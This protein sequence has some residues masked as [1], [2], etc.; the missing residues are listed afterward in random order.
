MSL[1]RAVVGARHSA[2]QITWTKENGDP[3]DLTGSTVTGTIQSSGGTA[4]AIDG[5]LALVTPA[6]GI[7]SWEYGAVDVGAA[8][9]F[10][11]QF[12]A[13]YPGGAYDLSFPE[14]WV[15]EPVLD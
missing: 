5:T 13:T 14:P 3:H 8:G 12:K 4:R 11:V 1:P 9:T 6:S 10:Q 2:V 7:F 15:V